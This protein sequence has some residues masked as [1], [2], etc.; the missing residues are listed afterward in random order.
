MSGNFADIYSCRRGVFDDADTHHEE[1][2]GGVLGTAMGYRWAQG[3]RRGR[4]QQLNDIDNEV[5]Q[6]TSY[7]APAF[8]SE[9][10]V[11]ENVKQGFQ[12]SMNNSLELHL[13]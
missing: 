4:I 13:C 9:T 1:M 7:E 3:K 8:A 5:A 11:E 6:F 10:V 2:S 12:R